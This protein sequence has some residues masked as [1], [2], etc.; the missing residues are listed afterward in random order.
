MFTLGEFAARLAGMSADVKAAEEEIVVR[1]CKMIQKTAKGMI[2]HEQPYWPALAPATIEDKQRKG[3]KVPA[4]LLRTGEMRDSIQVNAPLDENGVTVGYVFSDSVIAKYQ[5]LGTSKIPP[6]PFLGAAAMGRERD[7]H[8]MAGKVFMRTML[9]GG[10]ETRHW[11][12][13]L[14]MLHK[15]ADQF[16]DM[17]ELDEDEDKR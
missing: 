5:E 9:H 7:I 1:G 16:K 6:R 14:H 3:F 15:A 10:E 17:M 4:P 2:G 12:H 11:R 13:V 8:E